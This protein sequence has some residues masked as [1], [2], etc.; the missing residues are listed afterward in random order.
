[1]KRVEPPADGESEEVL[2]KGRYEV[3][4]IPVTNT[5]LVPGTIS[6]TRTSELLAPTMLLTGH[7]GAIY[8]IEFDP[9]GNNLASGSFD[10][11]ICKPSFIP[12]LTHHSSLEHLWR[13]R[14][15][16]CPRGT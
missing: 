10:S 2:K 8:S 1:M 6:S 11:N 15:L 3:A 13:V 14:E 12:Y 16:Q 4:T 9:T 5:E 7:E